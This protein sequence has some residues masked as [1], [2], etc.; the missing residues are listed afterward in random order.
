[1]RPRLL[2]AL[3]PDALAEA[4]AP[5]VPLPFCG[6]LPPRLRVHQIRHLAHVI[7]HRRQLDQLT[8]KGDGADGSLVLVADD[9]LSDGF[10]LRLGTAQLVL[11]QVNGDEA[12]LELKRQLG[13]GPVGG[14]G[15]DVVEEAGEGEGGGGEGGGVGG[16]LLAGDDCC[17][18]LMC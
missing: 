13:A 1:M 15:A 4:S 14:G 17:F 3:G 9:G 11:D 6:H 18:C 5:A 8:Q 12:A 10:G 16:E 7:V 2:L